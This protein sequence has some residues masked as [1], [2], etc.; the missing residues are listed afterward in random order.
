MLQ[1]RLG[2]DAPA[3]IDDWLGRS[4]IGFRPGMT[5]LEAWEAGRGVWKLKAANVLAQEEIQIIS[6]DGIVRAVATITGIKKC[7]DRQ[8]VEGD[9][10]IGD[11]RVG[12]LT[13]TPHRSR[14]SVEYF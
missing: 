1:I 4:R 10:L 7:G 13:T 9:L 11:P 3:L 6:L 5:E 2:H 14:N 8:A 12:K